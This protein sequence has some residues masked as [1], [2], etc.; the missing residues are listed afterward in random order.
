MCEKNVANPGAMNFLYKNCIGMQMEKINNR[1][2]KAFINSDP[3]EIKECNMK[4]V[5]YLSLLISTAALIHSTKNKITIQY[6]HLESNHLPN[7]HKQIY[8]TVYL[9]QFSYNEEVFNESPPFYED[10]L[11]QSGY[12]NKL[13][14]SLL[15]M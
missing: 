2:Q 9:S 8:K 15:K 13:N 14:I 5:N 12:Q 10:K 11:Y 7:I 1:L 3:N 4:I 6:I